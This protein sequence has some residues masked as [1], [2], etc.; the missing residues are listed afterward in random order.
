M[1]FPRAH[2]IPDGENLTARVGEKG[3]LH[4]L[5]ETLSL[6]RNGAKVSGKGS[7]VPCSGRQGCTEAFAK[8]EEWRVP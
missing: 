6:L 7:Q 8:R 5:D 2:V 3:E 1:E 4:F